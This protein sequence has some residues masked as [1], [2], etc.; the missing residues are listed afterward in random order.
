MRLETRTAV[1]EIRT[2]ASS[3]IGREDIWKPE[4]KEIEI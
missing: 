3:I 2:L 4:A 1:L